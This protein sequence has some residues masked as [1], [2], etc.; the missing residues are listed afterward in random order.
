MPKHCKAP[1]RQ[2]LPPASS[3]ARGGTPLAAALL[4]ACLL[5]ACGGSGENGTVPSVAADV[6]QQPGTTGSTS[7]VAPPTPALSGPPQSP[8]PVA[9]AALQMRCP[10]GVEYQCSGAIPLRSDNGIVLS[11]SGVQAYG[12]STSDLMSPNPTMTSAFGLAPAAGGWAEVRLARDAAGGAT[13]PALILRNL[14]LSWDG[15]N[16][17]P[18]IVETFRTT[19]GRIVLDTSERV[20][21]Q[22]LLPSAD[23]GFYDFATRGATGATQANYASNIYFP[24]AGNPA[25]CPDDLNPC[26]S[27]ETTGLRSS[28]GDWR[29]GGTEPDIASAVRVHED[30]DVHAGDGIPDAAGRSTILPGGSGPGVPFPGSKGY[31]SFDNWGY[32]YSNLTQWLTQDTVVFQEWAGLGNE[33]NKNRRGMVAYGEVTAPDA[34]PATGTA[35][36]NG[37]VLGW[38]AANGR[39]EPTTLR[40]TATVTVNFA[41]R[42]ALIAFS[43][44]QSSEAGGTVPINFSSRAWLGSSGTN[45]AN[46]FTAAAGDG[47]LRG[48]ISGRVFG[49]SGNEA[50]EMA[51]VFSLSDPAGGATVIGGFITRRR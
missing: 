17:R 50:S 32:R 13:S 44:G 11:A 10:D 23:L 48:G 24:R 28:P 9:D 8:S 12:R 34:V 36:Y 33:H 46:Y 3:S 43:N 29:S 7:T 27:T 47:N 15:R 37:V 39:T 14:G 38:Y 26:P 40:G 42:E 41:T 4:G 21:A 1:H 49:S 25:R 20:T 22:P 30:G 31:R 51:G 16:E 19:A 45:V 35:S 5:S 2:L 6:A 18:P